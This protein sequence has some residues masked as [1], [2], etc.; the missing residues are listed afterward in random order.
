[1]YLCRYGHQRITDVLTLPP[2]Q[3]I[4]AAEQLG[5]FVKIEHDDL[6]QSFVLGGDRHP[7]PAAAKHEQVF[8]VGGDIEP[9]KLASPIGDRYP[10]GTV[11]VSPDRVLPAPELVIAEV[12]GAGR[13]VTLRGRTLPFANK[14]P[15]FD[16][17]DDLELSG[18]WD[19]RRMTGENAPT[20]SSPEVRGQT[21][22]PSTLVAAILAFVNDALT[23]KVSFGDWVR[24]G[25]LL[26]LNTEYLTQTRVAWGMRF[27]W[28][29]DTTTKAAVDIAAAKARTDAELAR[30][31][32]A[33][34]PPTDRASK[35][36]RGELREAL[37]R[38][39]AENGSNTPDFILAELLVGTVA[40]FNHAVNERDRWHGM[41]QLKTINA[42]VKV[43]LRDA[44]PHPIVNAFNKE[45]AKRAS[46]GMIRKALSMVRR[47]SEDEPS[48]AERVAAASAGVQVDPPADTWSAA[49]DR[50]RAAI[51]AEY[52]G[53]NGSVGS[54]SD[55]EVGRALLLRNADNTGVRAWFWR[56]NARPDGSKAEIMG[57][58]ASTASLTPD[59]PGSYLVSLLVAGSY[60][61]EHEHKIVIKAGRVTAAAEAFNA[62]R[63]HE[64]TSK[65]WTEISDLLRERKLDELLPLRER[66]LPKMVAAALDESEQR[67]SRSLATV[68]A[69]VQHHAG[70]TTSELV[71]MST[72]DLLDIAD[73]VLKQ[74]HRDLLATRAEEADLAVGDKVFVLN[75]TVT[76]TSLLDGRMDV[77]VELSHG[78]RRE[79]V[80]RTLLLK[81]P[82]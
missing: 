78:G 22:S 66:T 40:A 6:S 52:V 51:I 56:L 39:S 30:E 25:R 20:I 81:K 69:F 5:R 18:E 16:Q 70:L 38:C 36:L 15:R 4:E 80:S 29:D 68:A 55:V 37:N 17:P 21:S 3:I 73:T 14:D 32:A 74:N 71:D 67:A 41:A 35:T 12:G 72:A 28:S 19:T 79:H 31:D 58:V 59:V 48:T 60:R 76:V 34:T 57:A 64:V 62:K 13:C 53:E 43:D 82:A 42:A 8:T 61:H 10:A 44:D 46:V 33:Y 1:M 2:E 63:Y 77:E 49:S 65:Q 45:T 23:V 50:A 47:G 54:R 27:R 26:T 9:T 24:Y 75:R 11:G 7:A